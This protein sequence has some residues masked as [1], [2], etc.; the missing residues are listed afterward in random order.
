M[1][2]EV[3]VVD[4]QTWY[5]QTL[6]SAFMSGNVIDGITHRSGD[7]QDVEVF[8][9]ITV[10]EGDAYPGINDIIK[11]C[12]IPSGW[13]IGIGRIGGKPTVYAVRWDMAPRYLVLEDFPVFFP[14]WKE[15]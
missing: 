5:E 8:L 12:E 4:E 7:N 1:R 9:L 14:M 11:E 3:H 10:H 15:L 6:G 13:S 2:Y